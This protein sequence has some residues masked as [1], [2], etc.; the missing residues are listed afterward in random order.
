MWDGLSVD[1][2]SSGTDKK[3][4]PHRCFPLLFLSDDQA[5]SCSNC[6]QCEKSMISCIVLGDELYNTL[7]EF[8]GFSVTFLPEEERELF[9]GC[10][11]STFDTSS[12]K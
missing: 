1:C 2:D 9:F 8:F 11:L 5:E 7:A 12:N 3:Q 4:L 6:C 10:E